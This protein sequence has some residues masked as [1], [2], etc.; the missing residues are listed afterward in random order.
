MDQAKSFVDPRS[1]FNSVTMTFHSLRPPID[2]PPEDTP[3]SAA[4]YAF[5][6]RLNS[7]CP[8][9]VALI[10]SATGQRVSYSE[11]T[12]KTECLTSYLRS[13]IGLSK[14]DTAFILSPNLVQVPILY[15]SLLTLGVVISPANPISTELEISG[16]VQLCNP[17]IAFATSSTAHK[18]PTLRF[19]T[20]RL[21]SPEFDS[22]MI[23]PVQRLDR[24]AVSQSDLAAI[25]YSSGTTGKVK[26]ATLTHRNLMAV[27]AV[28]CANRLERESPDLLLYT[29]P[30]FHVFGLSYCLKSVALSEAQVVMERFDLRK[31]L[32][33]VEEFRVTHV[34]LSP[35]VVVPMAKSDVIDGYDL[36]S[37]GGVTSGGA[38]LG[39]D[40]IA[41]FVARFPSVVFVQ[42][43]GLTEIAG[44]SFITAG[45]EESLHWGSAG[46]LAGG[47]EVKIV[48]PVTGDSLPPGKQGELWIKGPSVMKGYVGDPEA[49]CATIVADGWL[50]T[51]DLCYIDK[52]GFLFVTDRLKELIK[53]KGYQVPP[54]EL[55]QLLQSHPE[56]ADAAVIPCPDEEAGEVPMA[57][58][59]RQPQSR[60]GGPEIMDFVA[61]Q[62]APYK[63]IRRVAFVTSIPKSAAGKILRKDLRK[64]LPSSSSRL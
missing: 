59:V 52:E 23:S 53:Y 39:K 63:K 24:V 6:L 29:V 4:A 28:S 9:S 38:P 22:M 10:N 43:Y 15:F 12:R 42:G 32:R 40:V 18:L 50:R 35:P 61:K 49:T 19:K 47:F 44:G 5:S 2:L 21:D 48:D 25:M 36:S 1:G 13:V 8:D 20:I 41:A 30:Y 26:G 33:A 3:I 45:H 14:G 46:R 64:L 54:A 57:F 11:F 16:L 58:V 34:A 27:V 37:L 7:P 56:I 55:E 17:V 60:L 62:V 51:G 31:M